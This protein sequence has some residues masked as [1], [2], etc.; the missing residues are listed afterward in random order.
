MGKTR[1]FFKK[2]RNTKGTFHAKMGSIKD[3]NG[4]DLTE[5]E[6]I[7]KRW[8]EYTR[9]NI[10]KRSPQPRYSQWWDHSLRARHLG[11]WSQEG[12]RKHHAQQSK[13]RWWNSNWTIS[14]PKSWCYKSAALKRK[15]I[16]KTQQW[17][18]NWQR[19]AFIPILKK[20]NAKECSN[21]CTIALISHSNKV[22]LKLS[23]PGFNSTWTV[24]FQMFKLDLEKAEEPE[25]VLP[26][27]VGSSKKQESFRKISTSALLTMPKPLCGPQQTL[28]NF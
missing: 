14:N 22:M 4:M 2:I 23:K 7:K 17:P 18:Q 19:S 12:L 28:E 15:H 1:D 5:A 9:R 20:G 13:W 27:S 24:N 25:I 26:T 21:Y 10:K 16:W 8:Q 3:K 11:V 6:D